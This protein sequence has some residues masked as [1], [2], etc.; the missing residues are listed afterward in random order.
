MRQAKVQMIGRF[1][2]QGLCKLQIVEDLGQ[3][4]SLPLKMAIIEEPI[5]FFCFQR[6]KADS[7][8]SP[9][10]ERKKTAFEMAL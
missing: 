7:T 8:L 5:P 1:K 9:S 3:I 4:F 6:V 10:K 2:A